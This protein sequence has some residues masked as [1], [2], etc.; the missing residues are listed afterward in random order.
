M[1]DNSFHTNIDQNFADN[2]PHDKGYNDK[3]TYFVETS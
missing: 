3:D 2:E 1:L